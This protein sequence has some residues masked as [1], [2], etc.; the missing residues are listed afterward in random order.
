MGTQPAPA[1]AVRENPGRP[2]LHFWAVLPD[3]PLPDF[4][5]HLGKPGRTGRT[6]LPSWPHEVLDWPDFRVPRDREQAEAAIVA[7]Y[8][9]AREGRR[10]EVT[11]GG[12]NGRTGTVIACL[13]VLAGHPAT[14]AVGWTRRTY[15]R[16]AVETWWQRR[17]VRQFAS[18]VGPTG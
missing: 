18:R 1:T 5:L 11:C 16:H 7:A 13:A 17:W 3:G 10:V 6:G 15:R 14:D 2:S 9:L 8:Q 4:A 12:G